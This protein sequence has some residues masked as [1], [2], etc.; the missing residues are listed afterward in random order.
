MATDH[1]TIQET[2]EGRTIVFQGQLHAAA[3]GSMCDDLLAACEEAPG[4][5]AFDLGGVTFV[6]SSFLRLVLTANRKKARGE[7]QVVSVQPE[8]KKVFKMAGLWDALGME[9]GN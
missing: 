4:P 5:L 3:C 6:S 7:F 1:Y 9:R 2:G 8:V